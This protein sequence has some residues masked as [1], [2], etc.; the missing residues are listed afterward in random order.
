MIPI[1]ITYTPYA[2]GVKIIGVTGR[3]AEIRIP[4][5]IGGL[6]VIAITTMPLQCRRRQR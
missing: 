5:H 3:A 4:D 2:E 6:P 1:T